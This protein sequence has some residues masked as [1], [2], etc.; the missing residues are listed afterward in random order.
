M[1]AP[2]LSPVARHA[3][4]A[5]AVPMPNSH[6]G[7]ELHTH[8]A[9]AGSNPSAPDPHAHAGCSAG[10]HTSYHRTVK[11]G[12]SSLGWSDSHSCWGFG[13]GSTGGQ[14]GHAPHQQPNASRGHVV[15]PLVMVAGST[16]S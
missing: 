10:A 5:K 2:A 4:K 12:G 8:S 16:A 3:Y 6:P 13:L 15:G 11:E 7:E 1:S 9:P 14:A